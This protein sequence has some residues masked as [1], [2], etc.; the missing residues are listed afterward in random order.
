MR[1]NHYIDEIITEK[2]TKK[3]KEESLKN[4]NI[5]IGAEFE[6]KLDQHSNIDNMLEGAKEDFD[7]YNKSVDEYNENLEN[8]QEEIDELKS[9]LSDLDDKII[10]I[11]NS[12]EESESLIEDI[13]SEIEDI[14]NDIDNEE[15]DSEIEALNSKKGFLESRKDDLYDSI[16][17]DKSDLSSV[18]SKYDELHDKIEDMEEYI[19]DYVEY[20]YFD[21][22]KYSDYVRFLDEMI[23]ENIDVEIGEYLPYDPSYYENEE[24]FVSFIENNG[25]LDDFPFSDYE[26]GEYG[27]VSQDVGDTT[28]AIENDQSVEG[29]AEVKS[30]PMPLDEFIP[31]TLKDMLSWINDVGY[32]DNQCGLHIHM[33]L[34]DSNGIDPLKLLLFVEEDYIFKL[35]PGRKNN[36]YTKSINKKIQSKGFINKK[37]INTLVDIKGLMVKIQSEHFDGVNIIDLDTGHVEFRYMGGDYAN[38][39]NDIVNVISTYSYWLSLSSDPEFK[40][41][42]YAHK[43]SRSLNKIELYE[44]KFYLDYIAHYLNDNDVMETSYLKVK[45]LYDEILKKKNILEKIYKLSK[46]NIKNIVDNTSF[47]NSLNDNIIKKINK[48]VNKNDVI[49][50][51]NMYLIKTY[52]SLPR[53]NVIKI[54]R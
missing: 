20:P 11:E 47:N 10:E 33:S 22:Y 12:I 7:E 6:F 40:K 4:D 25:I 15:D 42:E 35:F 50:D 43:I 3:E 21:Q 38:S 52:H 23:G 46:D 30:P 28:W 41:K 54:Q 8:H 5:I 14:D 45:V 39:Y 36:T 19:N 17:N 44:Y 31:S 37:N 26:V 32:T 51:G 13:D 27:E 48:L 53:G 18:S 16:T 24:S 9:N 1:L 2:V 34:E 49:N 29:G